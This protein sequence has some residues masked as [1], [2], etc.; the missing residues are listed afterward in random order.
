LE[1]I[2]KFQEII[3]LGTGTIAINIAKYC[4]QKYGNTKFI[5]SRSANGLS[6]S[7]IC[8]THNIPFFAFEK[9]EIDQFLLSLT[10]ETLIIS[11]SN[12]YLFP[13]MIIERENLFIINYHSSLLPKYPGRN[14]EAWTIFGMEEQGGITWHKVVREVDKGDV[15]YQK[16]INLTKLTTSFNLLRQYTTIAFDGFMEFEN[17]LMSNEVKLMPQE[18][19]VKNK[20][21]Y[22]KD[23]PNNGLLNI[24]WTSKE[25]SAFL[26]SMDYGPLNTLGFPKIEYEGVF[27]SIKKYKIIEEK[28][29][30]L[31]SNIKFDNNNIQLKVS[32]LRFVLKEL[33][34]LL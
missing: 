9:I 15:I 11:A 13:S 29:L 23:L 28:D 24:E 30:V 31:N 22:S 26:R 3:V 2:Y 32:N 20:H 19:L 10:K 14:A 17:D 16:A 18:Y 27:Y 25:I 12:R 34:I 1:V 5:E 33:E 4:H 6:V 7:K 21:Y 8:E